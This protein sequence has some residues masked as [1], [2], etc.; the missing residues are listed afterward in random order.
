MSTKQDFRAKIGNFH[1]CGKYG[2]IQLC[3]RKTAAGKE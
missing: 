2:I 1:D 3:G